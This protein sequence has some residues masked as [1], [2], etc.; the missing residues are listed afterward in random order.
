MQNTQ[1]SSNENKTNNHKNIDL[2]QN[3]SPTKN[4]TQISNKTTK[5]IKPI[6]KTISNKVNLN[7]QTHKSSSETNTTKKNQVRYPQEK[8]T[9]TPKI[10]R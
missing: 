10:L 4:Q 8:Q 5:P 7:L 9:K 2:L 6:T 3:Q 1:Q